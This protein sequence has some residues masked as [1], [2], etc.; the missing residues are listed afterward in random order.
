MLIVSSHGS[1]IGTLMELPIEYSQ[2]PSKETMEL[3]NGLSEEEKKLVEEAVEKNGG[4]YKSN[5]LDVLTY[6]KEKDE[7][8]YKKFDHEIEQV[9]EAIKAIDDTDTFL[10][11]SNLRYEFG[12]VDLKDFNTVLRQLAIWRARGKSLSNDGKLEISNHLR[13]VFH[14]RFS[15][16]V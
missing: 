10:F 15:I 12:S 16:N 2:I 11:I 6:I 13:G 9:N 8:L 7:K 14:T 5:D 3:I 4:Q 1:I